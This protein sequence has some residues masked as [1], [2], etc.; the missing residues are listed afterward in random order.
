MKNWLTKTK[1][2]KLVFWLIFPAAAYLLLTFSIRFSM[3]Y[4]AQFF[5]NPTA[6]I[7]N[8]MFT[9]TYSALVYSSVLAA[10]YFIPKRFFGFELSKKEIG[11]SKEITFTDF[12]LGIIGL[13]ISLILAGAL[14]QLAGQFIPNFD[15]NQ[16]QNLGY[17]GLVYPYQFMVVFCFL[18]IV[19]A[20]VE[21]TIFRGIIYGELRQI[22]PWLAM[23]LVSILF[24][25]AHF[26]LNVA[27]TTFAMSLVMCF[28]REKFTDTIWAGVVLHFLKN[29]LAFVLLYMMPS[30]WM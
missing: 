11:F 12:A 28:I 25:A 5:E 21:E 29:A 14:T 15:A 17:Y 1:T 23:I 19:P 22:N 8:P 4:L 24:G 26:Q 30:L 16:Q 27:I 13:I 18:A 6:L 9:A 10:I 7:A 2:G 20:I 3:V